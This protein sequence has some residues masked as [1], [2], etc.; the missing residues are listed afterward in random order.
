MIRWQAVLLA[1]LTVLIVICSAT[2]AY[3]DRTYYVNYTERSDVNYTVQLK[4]NDFY[5]ESYLEQDRTYVATLIDT[6]HANFVYDLNTEAE[7]V[8]Y[9]YSY[10][11]EAQLLIKSAKSDEPIFDPIYVIE[12]EQRFS[13]NAKAP[14]RINESVLLNYGEYNDVANRFIETYD[15]PETESALIVRLH[16]KVHSAVAAMEGETTNHHVVELHIPLTEKAVN[17]EMTSSIPTA[18]VKQIACNGGAAK[19]VF[20]VAAIVLGVLELFLILFLIAFVLLT[21]TKDT[22]YAGKVKR[23]LNN[24]KSY[25]QRINN[26][27]D[28]DGYQVLY[29]DTFGELLEIRETIQ[30]PILVHENEDKTRTEFVIPTNTKL[31]YLYC[32]QVEEYAEPEEPI[33]EAPVVEEPVA[34]EPIIVEAPV[35]EVAE[36]TAEEVAEEEPVVVAVPEPEPEPQPEPIQEGIEVIGVV[37]PEHK[38]RSKERIYRYD[39]NGEKVDVGDVVLVPS[40]DVDS[41]KEIVREAEVAQANYFADPATIQHPLKKIICVVRRKAEQVFTSMI[42]NEKEE[43]SDKADGSDA[44]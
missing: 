25:I 9:E 6:V 27:F 21:R 36:E 40:T 29:V 38:G 4:E 28:K 7:D 23:I 2:Y 34:E 20:M 41:Q 30:A 26:P 8:N 1:I 22:T 32:L 42:L 13:Y 39:P 35:E 44:D 10:R 14:L 16:V 31:L 12:P 24:Y 37:W 5:E 19:A 33:V 11:T 3:I 43:K 17:I 18:E 15:L